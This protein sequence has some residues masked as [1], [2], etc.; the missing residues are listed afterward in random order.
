MQEEHLLIPSEDISVEILKKH[1]LC[2]LILDKSNSQN[3]E[4]QFLMQH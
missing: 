1:C 4:H 2:N 3:R